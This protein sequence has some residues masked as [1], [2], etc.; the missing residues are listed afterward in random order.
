M[1]KEK[2]IIKWIIE[3][4]IKINQVKAVSSIKY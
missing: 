4:L 1:D 3:Y 2:L